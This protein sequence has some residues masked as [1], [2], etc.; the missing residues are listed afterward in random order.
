MSEAHAPPAPAA[1]P[2][3]PPP[4]PAGAP[5]AAPK[6]D[7]APAEPMPKRFGKYTLIRKLATGGMAELF[8]AL[9]RSVAGF[10]KL[11]VVKR[12]LPHLAKDTAFIEMLLAEAR[13][14]ATLNHPNVAHIY[15][16]GVNDGQYYIAMEYIHGEDLRSIVRGMKKKATTSFPLEHALM[17]VLSAC[18]GLSYAHDKV[19]L[20]GTPMNI[21]HRDVS[22]QNIVV[23]FSGDVKLVDFGIA[24]AGRSTHEDTQSG[25]LKGKIPYMSP[26]Q[27][28]GEQVDARSDV[29]SLGV[30]LF[31]L[32][33]GRRLFRGSNEFETMKMIVEQP[34]PAPRSINP[35]LSPRLEEIINKALEKDPTK[36][37]QSAR[38]MQVDLE[39]HIRNEKLAASP[40][41]LGEWMRGLFDEK[42]AAQE[43][44]L[45]EGRQLADVIAQQI[46]DE[47]AAEALAA[48]TNSGVR[49]RK[50]AKAPWIL[51]VLLAVLAVAGGGYLALRPPT[52]PPVGP[53]V[54]SVRS[55]PPRAAIFIDGALRAERTPAGLRGLPVPATYA[56]KVSA[57]GY[58]PCT[59]QVRLT[60]ARPT[61]NV[62]CTLE[63]PTARSY[64]ILRV[65]TTPAGAQVLFDGSDTHLTTPATVPE[66]APGVDHTVALALRDYVT[67]TIT[68]TLRAGQVEDLAFEL[69]RTPLGPSE[70]IIRVTTVPAEARVIFGEG[71]WHETGSPYEFRVP[72]RP[73]RL[74]VARGGYR[75]S[76]RTVTLPGGRVTELTVEL[77]RERQTGVRQPPLPPPPRASGPGRLTFDARPWCN[78]SVDGRNLGQTPIVNHELASGPHRVTCTNPELNV[79]RT[80]TVQIAPGETTRQRIPLQ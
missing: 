61:A 77:E 47:E 51:V 56:I 6:P 3:P 20:D 16:V 14:A 71:N 27:A 78:V 33:T 46:A 44:A 22:P 62:T 57:E 50:G 10:E 68:I 69:E 18:A 40:L 9:Q 73:Y 15:D 43:K 37:Y 42:L 65:R 58:V 19:D 66:I 2:P 25:K 17:I 53:G 38:Q 67:K 28:R 41:S 64:G 35:S 76:E 80:I 59:Q 49:N 12:I 4:R 11:I 60:K 26:E 74:V 23:T 72:A 5:P 13:I 55:T 32:C 21:V 45:K 36:R 54:V 34:Y 7:E 30:I 8:L 79:T 29:F 48:R 70:A 1:P 63:R 75:T 39:E 24:K 52:G 31:E